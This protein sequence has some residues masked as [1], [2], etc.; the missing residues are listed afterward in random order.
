MHPLSLALPALLAA[1]A[2]AQTPLNY[3]DFWSGCTSS[4]SRG[5][6]GLNPGEVLQLNP[7]SHFQGVGHDATG[8]SATLYAF[9][10]TT[11]D[12]DA[13]TPEPYTLLVRGESA[14]QPDPTPAGLLLS[15]GPLTTPSGTGVTAWTITATLNTP[16]VGLPLCAN[17]YHG[18]DVAV[19]SSTAD[20]QTFHICNYTAADIPAAGAANLAWNI[21]AGT[22]AQP[23]TP[24]VIRFTLGVQSPILKMGNVD[25]GTPSTNC[26][27]TIGFRSF[28]A[29]GMY[30]ACNT[31]RA[32]G[33]DYRVRDAANAGGVCGVFLG[34]GIGCPGVPLGGLAN[35]ALYLN[36]A[37]AFLQIGSGALD[38]AG[39]NIGTVLPPGSSACRAAVNRQLDF[40]AFTVG[41]T[42][43]LP[44]NLTNRAGV[45]YLP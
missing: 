3:H 32:D 35:G 4:T 25:P 15:V 12:Q 45:T 9:K 38:A 22:P 39:E 2:A 29:G 7:S 20:G 11:Q 6:L 21:Q 1:T 36:P 42:F 43:S 28:G 19:R 34:I 23:G 31:V 13:S 37:G 8:T 24:R 10:Y 26:V 40:Q 5:T 30:P 18:A 14:G 41:P 16:W 33:L 44:G 27:S 17:Y